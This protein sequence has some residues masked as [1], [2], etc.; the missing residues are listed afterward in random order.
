MCGVV[1]FVFRDRIYDYV[2]ENAGI[3][4]TTYNETSGDY[5]Q[6]AWDTLHEELVRGDYS[7]NN[8]F[9]T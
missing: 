2:T 3:L 9:K 6:E 7:N 8:N 1:V 5:V 4:M